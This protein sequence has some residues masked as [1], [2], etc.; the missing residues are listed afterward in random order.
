MVNIKYRILDING[1]MQFGRGQQDLTYGSDA[2]A[3]AIKTRLLLLKGEWW[4]DA[5]DG[6][7][8]FQQILDTPNS[9]QNLNV[10]DSIIKQRILGTPNV[11]S[12]QEYTSSYDNRTYSFNCKVNTT[13]GTITVSNSL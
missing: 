5:E 7:P 10:V 12:I 6:L 8:L 13:Y 3:Q 2:V 9:T 4:E 11:L 1:D